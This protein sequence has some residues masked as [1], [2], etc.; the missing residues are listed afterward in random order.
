[1]NQSH[2]PSLEIQITPLWEKDTVSSAFVTISLKNQDFRSEEILCSFLDEIYSIPSAIDWKSLHISDEHGNI[3]IRHNS[4]PEQHQIVHQLI[5]GRKTVGMIR[6]SYRA[7]FAPARPNP[8]LDM[9]Q[10]SGGITGSGYCWMPS[11]SEQNYKLHLEFSHEELPQEVRTLWA[12]GEDCSQ[13]TIQGDALQKVFYCIGIVDCVE[14][15]NFGYY[16]IRR[17][18]FDA[19]EIGQWTSQVFLKMAD[20]FEDSKETY[21]IFAR[22]RSCRISGGTA[23]NRSYTYIYDP[24][25]L[26]SFTQL[27]F[28]FPHEMVHNWVLLYDE[29]YGTCTW[30]I[31]GMADYY[32][33][34]LP[35]RF[36][37]ISRE[38]LLAQ[39]N[40]KADQYYRNPCI[41]LTNL[42]LGNLL[43]HDLEATNVPYGRGLFYLMEVDHRIREK[44]SGQ[45]CLDDVM[46]E[47]LHRYREDKHLQ[48]RAWLD[49]ID[50]VAGFDETERFLAICQGEII[51]PDLSCFTGA[52]LSVE[53]V[54]AYMR[55]NHM[56][57]KT[58]Q[59]Y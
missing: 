20:F 37:L 29:P 51:L 34:I 16:W 52:D 1:M 53:E 56:S 55:R 41:A 8:V 17:K 27:K 3:E 26:P 38:E 15:G 19:T 5:L 42:R 9:G 48:N 58:Y 18:G 23:L 57:C 13:L 32:S 45:R 11:F 47:I 40:E 36:G 14:Q 50:K 49:A 25:N 30:Y 2:I 22:A 28:L 46:L 33:M 59:F 21:K 44:T 31:E 43:F 12:H 54:D 4:C 6:I 35:W 7:N 39:L 24:E 10:E